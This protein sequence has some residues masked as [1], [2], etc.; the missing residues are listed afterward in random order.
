MRRGR[1]AEAAKR[2][3]ASRGQP[4]GREPRPALEAILT[5]REREREGGGQREREVGREGRRENQHIA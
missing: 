1:R 5:Q 4:A 2:S 3:D